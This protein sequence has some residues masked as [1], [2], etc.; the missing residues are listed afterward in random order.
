MKALLSPEF[1]MKI[2]SKTLNFSSINIRSDLKTKKNGLPH[3][4]DLCS[5]KKYLS[6]RILILPPSWIHPTSQ[7]IHQ[8]N[9]HS[10]SKCI[11]ILSSRCSSTFW[12]HSVQLLAAPIKLR[13]LLV[14]LDFRSSGES[15]HQSIIHPSI[16][17]FTHPSFLPTNYLF[18]FIKY[19]FPPLA[20]LISSL[21]FDNMRVPNNHY[22]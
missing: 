4:L 20:N 18:L 13:N 16:H 14:S 19:L 15:I 11:V 9:F 22:N 7:L 3:L 1:L 8:A 21:E 6:L 10:C 5:L 2:P 12:C 17:S